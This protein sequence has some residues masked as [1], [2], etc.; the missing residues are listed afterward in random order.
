MK[1][2]HVLPIQVESFALLVKR[3]REVKGKADVFEIWLDPMRVKGDLAVIRTHFNVPIMGKTES[4]DMAKRAIKSGLDYVDI[5]TGLWADEEM[6][7]LLKNKP[8]KII[9][10]YHNFEMT[11]SEDELNKIC[12]QMQEE[13]ADFYKIAT[14]IQTPEDEDRLLELLKTH[15]NLTVTGMGPHARRIRIEAP[16]QGSTFYYAPLNAETASA[17]GQLTRAELEEEWAK[18]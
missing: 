10:S 15:E 18:R 3:L 14:W 7:T 11:P 6:G 4:L 16:L 12:A 17:S 13:K 8:A 1:S 2:K 9:R 5:P